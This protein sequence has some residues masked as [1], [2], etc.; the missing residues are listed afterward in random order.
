MQK[1]LCLLSLLVA[2]SAAAQP[3]IAQ[4]SPDSKPTARPAPA[5]RPAARAKPTAPCLQ[6]PQAVYERAGELIANG[7]RRGEL[8]YL[9]APDDREYFTFQLLFGAAFATAF[10]GEAAQKKLEALLSGFGIP[11]EKKGPEGLDIKDRKAVDAYAHKLLE[12]VDLVPLYGSLLGFLNELS[13]GEE[14]MKIENII[15]KLL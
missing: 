12:G 2:L 11:L 6:S 9:H 15:S 7:E 1:T 8:V 14:G 13:K 5:S 3:L 4:D 10:K